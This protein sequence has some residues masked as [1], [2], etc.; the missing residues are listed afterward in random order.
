MPPF[1]VLS[2]SAALR[3]ELIAHART[4][5][6]LECC[7]LLAGRVAGGTAFAEARYE[8]GNDAASATA[9]ATNPRDML[10]AF[11]AMRESG[12]ELLA[13]YHSHPMSPPVPSTR[14]LAENTYDETVAHLIL[15]LAGPVPEVRAWWLAPDGAREAALVIRPVPR[16]ECP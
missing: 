12:L 16:A 10:R 4:C 5:A 7:G 13:V 1:E 15:S 6:P 3:A 8:V 14:D 2:L 9:Y 11:R